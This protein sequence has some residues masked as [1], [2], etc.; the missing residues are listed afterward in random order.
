MKLRTHR[1]PVPIVRLDK[2]DADERFISKEGFKHRP[3]D[4][5]THIDM[6]G[7][8]LVV[9][10]SPPAFE[11]TVLWSVDHAGHRVVRGRGTT[12]LA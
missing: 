8:G 3:G 12:V 1:G 10:V 2:L 9:A 7:L 5:V 4:Y 6:G 11:I